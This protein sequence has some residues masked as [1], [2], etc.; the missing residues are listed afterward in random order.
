MDT[1]TVYQGRE[2]PTY[3]QLYEGRELLS[4]ADFAAITK[5]AI[6]HKGTVIKSSS[7]TYGGYFDLTT[8]AAD[9]KVEI[10]LGM[11]S[12]STANPNPDEAFLIVY[13]ATYS[14]PGIV[15]EHF[16]IELETDAIPP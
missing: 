7:S 15:F 11:L 10:Q 16:K 5:V 4:T 9:K 14:T 13:N 2:N 12:L 3:F 6:E 1:I 8:Y